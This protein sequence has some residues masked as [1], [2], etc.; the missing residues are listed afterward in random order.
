M[1]E[2]YQSQTA[3]S[4]ENLSFYMDSQLRDDRDYGRASYRSSRYVLLR[5]KLELI[6][7]RSF[8]ML[9]DSISRLVDSYL[10]KRDNK[11]DASRNRTQM[12]EVFERVSNYLT[13][14]TD[15]VSRV[16]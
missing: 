11:K 1:E 4:L 15:E 12:Q 8:D 5:Q 9:F 16:K 14:S 13:S 6:P 2:S 7:D 3:I 10:G